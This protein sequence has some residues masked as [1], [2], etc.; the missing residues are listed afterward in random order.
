M[1]ISLEAPC[2]IGADAIERER[3]HGRVSACKNW[4]PLR[5]QILDAKPGVGGA[6]DLTAGDHVTEF[7]L[8]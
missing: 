6:C 8:D 4:M 1:V 3:R 2:L 5:G 7:Q